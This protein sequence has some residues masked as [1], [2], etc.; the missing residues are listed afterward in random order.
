MIEVRFSANMRSRFVD[1]NFARD[2][3]RRL[4]RFYAISG[5]SVM[6][7]ARRLLR[8]P[9]QMPLSEMS[10]LQRQRYRQRQQDYRRKSVR[11]KARRPDK[12]SKPGKPPLLHDKDSV[13]KRRLFF[14]LAADKQ[15]V[16]VGPELFNTGA[17]NIYGGLKSVQQLEQV[18]PFMAPA[19]EKVTPRIP[20]YLA[21][22]VR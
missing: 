20:G 17:S 9:V 4:I 1:S 10:E 18:R 5:A 15:S 13:L 6:T 7:T 11:T 12:V 21:K 3:E 8:G 16:V 19:L 22:A 2:I 14:A